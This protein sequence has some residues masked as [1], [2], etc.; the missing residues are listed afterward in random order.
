[1][2]D[3]WLGSSLGI[4]QLWYNSPL[5]Q[6]GPEDG[7]EL[8]FNLELDVTKTTYVYFFVT[9]QSITTAQQCGFTLTN[10]EGEVMI[11]V[12]FFNIIPFINESGWYKYEDRS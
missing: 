3:G 2:G 7:N 8:S 10:S 4:Y 12:P 5:Y 9:P 6:M 1:M 11:E